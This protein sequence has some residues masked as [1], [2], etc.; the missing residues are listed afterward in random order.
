VSTTTQR[1]T[2]AREQ[3][4]APAGRVAWRLAT[5]QRARFTR[6]VL[7][8]SVFWV[9]PAVVGLGLQA[10]FDRISGEAQ[11]GLTVPSLLVLLLVVEGG[12]LVVF[13]TSILMWTRWWVHSETLLRTNMLRA[14][15]ASGGR[16][17]GVPVRHSGSAVAVFRND[18]EDLIMYLDTWVDIVGTVVFGVVALAIMVRVD[19]TV[20]L[21]VVVPLLLAFFVT[22]ML[23]ERLRTYRRA[24]RE[25]TAH[26]TGFLG[27]LFSAVLAVKVAGAERSAIGRLQRLN[28]TRRRTVLRDRL[29]YETLEA[30]NGSTV[31]ISIGLVLLL[32][33][34]AMRSGDFTVGD[35]ALFA[36][37]VTWLAAL[38]RWTGRLLTR[39]RH[40]QVAVG[41]MS[42]LVAGSEPDGVVVHRP[43]RLDRPEPLPVR[44]RPS[45]SPAAHVAA[46]GLAHAFDD[47]SGIEG[48]DLDLAPGSFTVV[49]GPVGSGKTTLLRALLGL[50]D[51]AEGAIRWDG[52][53]V[54]EPAAFMVPPRTGYL[55]QVPRLFSAS[56][57][58]NLTLGVE[59]GDEALADAIRRA[60]LDRDVDGMDDGLDT[61]VGPRGVRLSGGQV[62]RAATARAL[63]ADPA[64]LV[65]DDL[66]SA[67]DADTERRL[68]AR[69]LDGEGGAALSRRP[70]CL[71]VSHRAAALERADQI[72]VMEGGRVRASGTLDELRARGLDPL[73]LHHR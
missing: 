71:V 58:E 34:P 11:A 9:T 45:A 41:R 12:R 14:Q 22:R 46:R 26:V 52:E 59:T 1:P 48:I 27:N 64:L 16:E 32:V 51:G 38:P 3:A 4:H 53:P 49:C 13:Y 40:A 37:Y 7:A 21:V 2:S 60:A 67:L 20:T 23:T 39:H 55:P 25:A 61:L 47:G 68:W 63:A 62:Q 8:W 44:P 56:L 17:A 69:L 31:E 19:A 57:R 36:T 35:L 70:T 29:L 43:L 15:L 65:L 30:F 28:A 5:Y 6:G 50:V 42:A 54:T 33:A 73:A 18:V 24:D 10:I 72:L 66:S